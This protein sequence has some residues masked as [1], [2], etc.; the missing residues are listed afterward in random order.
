MENNAG[1]G[2]IAITGTQTTNVTVSDCVSANNAIAGIFSDAVSGALVNIM[3]R[4]STVANNAAIGLEAQGTGAVVRVTRST[5]TGN[6]TGWDNPTGGVVLSYGDNNIDGN[7][8]VNTE[9]PSPLS[10]K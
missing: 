6:N 4:N 8:N 3:V 9:P 7:A 5:I 2:L 1:A 10:Y